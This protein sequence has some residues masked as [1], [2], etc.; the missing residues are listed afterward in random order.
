MAPFESGGAVVIQTDLAKIKNGLIVFEWGSDKREVISAKVALSRLKARIADC[1]IM[2]KDLEQSKCFHR[3]CAY[4]QGIVKNTGK[5]L[6]LPDLKLK[7]KVSID[8]FKKIK[9]VANE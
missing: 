9:A 2:Q 5:E 1:R 3:A 4:Y 8:I 7:N 6:K